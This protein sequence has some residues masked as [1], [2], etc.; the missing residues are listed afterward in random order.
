MFK[1][2]KEQYMTFITEVLHYGYIWGDN[3]I[4]VVNLFYDNFGPI[5]VMQKHQLKSYHN[6]LYVDGSR[7]NRF[8]GVQLSY[9]GKYARAE[10][11]PH[12]VE[13]YTNAKPKK[14]WYY[15]TGEQLEDLTRTEEYHIIE[16]YPQGNRYLVAGLNSNELAAHGITDDCKARTKEG[17]TY[18]VV[19]GDG[20]VVHQEWRTLNDLMQH[21]VVTLTGKGNAT[22]LPLIL[23]GM[24][25]T[26]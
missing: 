24:K 23:V 14:D 26:N 16:I 17:E 18:I 12:K 3:L 4:N 5:E 20:V 19:Y 25:K 13:Y 8:V 11:Y 7:V 15:L 6:T 10:Y 22:S 9:N 2:T 1:V 21:Q